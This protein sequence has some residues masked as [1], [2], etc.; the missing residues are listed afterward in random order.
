MTSQTRRLAAL[1]LA[2]IIVLL[3]PL[4]ASAYLDPGSG[5][6]FF[7]ILMGFFLAAAVSL[8]MAWGNV[9]MFVQ[10]FFRGRKNG[11]EPRD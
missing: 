10:N 1:G 6:Y 4:E 3:N 7:Q 2:G 5:S 9:K 8:R 11:T